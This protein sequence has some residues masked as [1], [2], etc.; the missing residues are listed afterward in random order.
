MLISVF[1]TQNH[2]EISHQEE[3][4]SFGT[5]IYFWESV[6]SSHS[7]CIK[8]YHFLLLKPPRT[9]HLLSEPKWKFSEKGK[10]FEVADVW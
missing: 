10:N 4:K 2:R 7:L 3:F 9:F 6:A 5:L 8:S 1:K